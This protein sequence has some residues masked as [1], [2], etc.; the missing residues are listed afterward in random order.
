M[1]RP[2]NII[3]NEQTPWVARQIE[4]YLKTNCEKPVF[5]LSAPLLLLTTEDRT[6]GLWRRTCLTYGPVVVLEREG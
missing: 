1:P 6:S 5:R 4:E 3:D 2:E